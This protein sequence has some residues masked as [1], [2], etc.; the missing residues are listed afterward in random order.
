MHR[1]EREESG[2][3]VIG[4]HS[5]KSGFLWKKSPAMA[6][7]LFFYRLFAY[8]IYIYIYMYRTSSLTDREW[9]RTKKK[10][11]NQAKAK[12]TCHLKRLQSR[13]RETEKLCSSRCQWFPLVVYSSWKS[14]RRVFT[15]SPPL[16]RHFLMH[17]TRRTRVKGWEEASFFHPLPFH[18]AQT[19]PFPPPPPSSW[20]SSRR[21]K[22]DEGGRITFVPLFLT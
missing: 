9:S 3:T 14:R 12:T 2:R 15:S 4:L 19:P 22:T 11:E 6:A 21:R 18:S 13:D 8:Y 1:R 10:K 17:R 7:R 16:F 5:R 20:F